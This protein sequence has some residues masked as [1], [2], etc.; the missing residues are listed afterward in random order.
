MLFFVRHGERADHVE[1]ERA[2]IELSHDPHLT[3][4]GVKQAFQTGVFLN[5]LIEEHE[6][7]LKNANLLHPEKSLKVIVLCS[8]FLRTIMTA[9]NIAQSLKNLHGGKV[10]LETA[11]GEYLEEFEFSGDVISKGEMMIR[12]RKIEELTKYFE[13][14]LE[15]S[16][17]KDPGLVYPIYP[18]I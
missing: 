7:N 6:N 1:S 3:P 12:L 4:Q 13:H 15:E 5:K 10:Y 9:V 16:F 14:P 11:I 18:A 8:P 17:I 2:K